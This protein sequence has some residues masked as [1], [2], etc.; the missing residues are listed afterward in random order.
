M[1]IIFS[2]LYCWKRKDKLRHSLFH[3]PLARLNLSDKDTNELF[4]QEEWSLLTGPSQTVG[5][6]KIA[7]GLHLTI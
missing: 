3:F 7:L 6:T 1:K 4:T 5:R 2:N